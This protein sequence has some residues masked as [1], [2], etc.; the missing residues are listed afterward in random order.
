MGE[1]FNTSGQR[2]LLSHYSRDHYR[3]ELEHNYITKQGQTWGQDRRCGDCHLTIH[4][5]DE[6]IQ[7]IGVTHRH[8][9]QFLPEKYRLPADSLEIEE[10]EQKET[11]FR[12]PVEF[13]DTEKETKKS[14]LVHLLM[15][16]YNKE[17][18]LEYRDTFRQMKVK[19]CPECGMALLDNYLGFIKHLAV[20]HEVVMKYV[21][22]AGDT[23]DKRDEDGDND[24]QRS[25]TWN[26]W[27]KW[28]MFL[29]QDPPVLA[30]QSTSP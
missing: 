14:L 18:E 27:R 2:A 7:H 8:V 22:D 13:C 6:Y 12:C 1:D 15:I 21:T 3:L 28:R 30:Q 29:G 10:K 24:H 9:L 25:G 17:M 4:S 20:E 26:Q 19:R 16:H 5:R 11:S 23:R